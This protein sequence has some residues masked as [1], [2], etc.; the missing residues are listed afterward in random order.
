MICCFGPNNFDTKVT[1][2]QARGARG[3]AVKFK[4][5]FSVDAYLSIILHRLHLNRKVR[6]VNTF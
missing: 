6:L 4:T 5:K 2:L 3:L 1:Q